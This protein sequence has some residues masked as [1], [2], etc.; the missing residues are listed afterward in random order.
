VSGLHRYAVHSERGHHTQLYLGFVSVLLTWAFAG[1]LSHFAITLPWWVESPSV[2]GMY[3]LL[4]QLF[5][6][7]LWRAGA[8]RQFLARPD[9]NGKWVGTLTSS[10]D[11]HAASTRAEARITQTW[12]HVSIAFHTATSE[13]ASESASIVVTPDEGAILTYEYQSVPNADSVGTMH[14]H[15]GTARLELKRE[16]DGKIMLIGDYYSGRDRQNF[17]RIEL[18]RFGP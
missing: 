3:G 2:L 12:T 5:D 10:F 13:S 7:H 18:R 16:R 14:T 11:K 8:I 4:Y 1:S 17:G 9:L 15:R 6:K